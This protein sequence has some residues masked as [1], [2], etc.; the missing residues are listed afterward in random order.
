MISSTRPVAPDRCHRSG[1]L[2]DAPS[3]AG[4]VENVLVL[5]D[6]LAQR[7]LLLQR[8]VDDVLTPGTAA[9]LVFF[10]AGFTLDEQQVT[11]FIY[12]VGMIVGGLPTLMAACDYF[13]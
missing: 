9:T 7:L 13:I 4:F 11:P 6:P 3:V 2:S 12:A 8:K 10:S 1:G 5:H